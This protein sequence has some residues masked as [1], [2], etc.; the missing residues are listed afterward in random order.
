MSSRGEVKITLRTQSF[1]KNQSL[2]DTKNR[3]KA[4][5]SCFSKSSS[6]RNEVTHLYWKKQ[7]LMQVKTVIGGL[8]GADSVVC[9]RSVVVKPDMSLEDAVKQV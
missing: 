7:C 9:S 6:R 8:T 2:D 1:I 5:L 3:M 4:A